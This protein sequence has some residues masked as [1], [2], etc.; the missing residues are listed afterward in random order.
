M[1]KETVKPVGKT[2]FYVIGIVGAALLLMCIA[3][4][5]I[6]HFNLPY[7]SLYQLGTLLIICVGV[8]ILVRN[9]VSDYAYS[10]VGE[11]LIISAKL[12]S[13]EWVVARPALDS[14]KLVAFHSSPDARKYKADGRYNAKKSFFTVNTYVCFFQ[15]DGKLYQLKFEPS[16]RLL[17]IL[18]KKGISI[19]K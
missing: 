10:I 18:E 15:Q 4:L 11:E 8:Y 13:H 5:A 17:S 19:S 9:V 6:T 14:I 3:D 7:R 16:T 12:G 2:I 1:Y